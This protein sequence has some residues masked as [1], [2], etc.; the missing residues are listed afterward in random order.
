MSTLSQALAPPFLLAGVILCLAGFAKLRDPAGAAEA[1]REVGL[2]AS[3][4]AVR[5]LAAVELVVGALVLATPGRAVA[6]V[7]AALYA[8]LALVSIRLVRHRASC[9][10]FGQNDA[11]SSVMQVIIGCCFALVAGAV[12]GSGAH[13]I[14]WLVERPV[15]QW[16][17]SALALAGAAYGVVLAYTALPE[18]WSSWSGR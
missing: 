4:W 3:A 7:C 9:G 13:G 6:A 14:G 1:A 18:V 8:F 16:V 5:A 15:S 17:V 2:P 11:P 12:V 10:C